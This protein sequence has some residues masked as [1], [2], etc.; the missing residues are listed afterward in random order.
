SAAF[1]IAAVVF[2]FSAFVLTAIVTVPL[3]A[4][5]WI[6]NGWTRTVSERRV[7]FSNI[8]NAQIVEGLS[9]A[10]LIKSTDRINDPGRRQQATVAE[11]VH[12]QKK[13]VHYQSL[14]ATLPDAFLLVA[15]VFIIAV[16]QIFRLSAPADFIFFLLLMVRAQRFV[17]QAQMFQQKAVSLLP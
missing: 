8:C 16:S 2:S 17:G 11:L 13:N 5:G 15:L 10:K 1:F 7:A 4:V 12:A 9:Q 3:L 14:M 6:I